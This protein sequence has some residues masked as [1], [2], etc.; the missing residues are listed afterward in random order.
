[1]F[2]VVELLTDGSIRL[3]DQG[4]YMLD[5]SSDID[6]AMVQAAEYVRTEYPEIFEERLMVEGE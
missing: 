1:M 6:E 4:E 2:I 5:L 3:L